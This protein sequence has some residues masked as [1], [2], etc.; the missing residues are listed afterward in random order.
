MARKVATFAILLG[1]MHTFS[2]YE[3]LSQSPQS[4]VAVAQAAASL[5][6]VS[7]EDVKGDPISPGQGFFVE[8]D[9]VATDYLVIKDAVRIRIQPEGQDA[10]EA[11]IAAVDPHWCFAL[12]R[13][14][15]LGTP[16][17][18]ACGPEFPARTDL[19][20]AG[21]AAPSSVRG[22][23]QA[24]DGGFLRLTAKVKSGLCG[25]PILNSKGLVAGALVKEHFADTIS[26]VLAPATYLR[27]ILRRPPPCG[28]VPDY[29][30]T[31]RP[32]RKVA[33]GV[34]GGIRAGAPDAAGRDAAS[35][36]HIKAS[37]LRPSAVRRAEPLY[38]A[39]AKAARVGGSV[40]V[41]VTIDE[42]GDVLSARCLSG[43]PLLIDVSLA[44]A[45][46]WKFNPTERDGTPVKVIGEIVFTFKL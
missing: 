26:D 2:S 32:G 43:H 39:M 12:L 31:D 28:S 46:G 34:P 33:D 7:G 10:I 5:V 29:R 18:V 17:R 45:R 36:Q 9:L 22:A 6:V 3:G 40:T 38:P 44:A 35:S 8:P 42:E 14:S 11:E 21:D 20:L 16:L 30:L 24:G 37:D 23:L 41:E 25:S 13:V 19:Y 27:S 1:L 15:E 4:N